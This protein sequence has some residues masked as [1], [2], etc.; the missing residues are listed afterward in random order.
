[1]PPRRK[2]ES[3]DWEILSGCVILNKLLVFLKSHKYIK[4]NIIALADFAELQPSWRFHVFKRVFEAN[5]NMEQATVEGGDC[6]TVTESGH[7][8]LY[9]I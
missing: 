8:L 7:E 5:M 2:Y 6:K 4:A 1:M 3:G 9:T